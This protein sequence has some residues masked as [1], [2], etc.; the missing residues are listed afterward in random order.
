[1]ADKNGDA[2]APAKLDAIVTVSRSTPSDVVR[3]E[4]ADARFKLERS[5]AALRDDVTLPS[6]LKRS[7]SKHPVLWLGGALVVGALLGKLSRRLLD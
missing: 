3:M 1:V 4:I 6:V 7:V 2:L 5:L